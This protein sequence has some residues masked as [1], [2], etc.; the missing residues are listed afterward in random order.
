MA[1]SALPA[2]RYHNQTSMGNSVIDALFNNEEQQELQKRR[3]TGLS[4]IEQLFKVDI[5]NL[6]PPLSSREQ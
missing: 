3:N 2:K 6:N 5:K 4:E 1:S